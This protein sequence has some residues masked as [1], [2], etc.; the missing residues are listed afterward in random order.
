MAS[1][2]RRSFSILALLAAG[3]AVVAALPRLRAEL[4]LPPDGQVRSTPVAIPEDDPARGRLGSLQFLGGIEMDSADPR[5]GGLSDLRLSPDGRRLVA[6]SDCGYGFSADLDLDA[7]GAPRGVTNTRLVDLVG[8]GG[9][10]LRMGE[11]DSE[12]LVWD[13]DHLDVGFEGQGRVWRYRAEPPFSLPVSPVPTPVGLIDCGPNEGL[14]TMALL[15]GGLRLLVCE[16]E[17]LPSLTVPAW[18]GSP[19]AWTERRYPLYFDGGWLGEPYRPTGA[20]RLPNGD[21]L[22]SERRFPPF[23]SR[24]VR[25]SK[26]NVDGDGPLAPVEIARLAGSALVDNYEGIEARTDERGRTLV[27]LVSDDN[28]CAKPGGSRFAVAKTRLLAFELLD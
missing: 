18:V 17:D 24:V 8:P 26:A 15:D 6:V 21:V 7:S 2:R 19:G 9:R 25:L 28:S 10:A 23:A 20:T 27:Y 22:V 13:A 1:A 16:G 3:L 14:E 12:S 4:T 11:N 5:F